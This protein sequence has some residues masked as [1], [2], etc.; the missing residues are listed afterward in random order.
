MKIAVITS[1][2][3]ET[4]SLEMASHIIVYQKNGESFEILQKLVWNLS[5]GISLGSYRRRIE[6][7]IESLGDC[8][9]IVASQ[10][11][12][13]AYNLFD[14]KGF[15]IWEYEG[16]P[17]TFLEE[18]LIREVV[19]QYELETSMNPFDYFKK[20]QEG[21]YAINVKEIL[22][23]DPQLTSKKLL[24]PFLDHHPF[25]QLQVTFSH[26]PPW[27]DPGLEKRHLKRTLI[28]HEVD[29]HVVIIEPIRD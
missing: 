28:L 9:V 26:L 24:L 3:G 11:L 13:L 29:T 27:L 15:H 18:I 14:L 2:I 10:L 23:K 25:D 21:H 17:E 5:E 22:Y 19:V 6:E 1:N 16:L 12:G 20:S 8:R 4:A 7:T